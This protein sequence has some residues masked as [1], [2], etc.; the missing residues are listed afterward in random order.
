MSK[1]T[2]NMLRYA[3]TCFSTLP[4]RQ[5]NPPHNRLRYGRQVVFHRQGMLAGPA[6]YSL[7]RHLPAGL[8]LR[9]P[10]RDQ[11]AHL[12]ANRLSISFVRHQRPP[13]PRLYAFRP[14]P[15]T[16]C[17]NIHDLANSLQSTAFSLPVPPRHQS[18]FSKIHDLFQH[19]HVMLASLQ[20]FVAQGIEARQ[21][22]TTPLPLPLHQI[23]ATR[24]SGAFI[25]R[26]SQENQ[27]PVFS[28]AA[29]ADQMQP[30]GSGILRLHRRQIKCAAQIP[31]EC[32]LVPPPKRH[33]SQGKI[34]QRIGVQSV[35]FIWIG[36]ELVATP[37]H[38]Q[39]LAT[40][41]AGECP[42]DLSYTFIQIQAHMFKFWCKMTPPVSH[43]QFCLMQP[44]QH[45]PDAR[46]LRIWV[47]PL[48]TIHDLGLLVAD[49]LL[50]TAFSLQP[51]TITLPDGSD[52][53]IC[54]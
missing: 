11:P 21:N 39:P 22:H 54:I 46:F 10:Q 7:I 38:I 4:L 6:V 1:H 20:E 14:N 30:I 50:L 32:R 3:S 35:V 8:C 49:F 41:R 47:V 12:R 29:A 27:L 42:C 16:H 40:A 5:V 44:G 18:A 31:F 13:P 19:E 33:I 26:E 45:F 34:G 53:I 43:R 37:G 2:I 28:D 23:H 52:P 48:R 51:F 17:P 25:R 36:D 24:H 9:Q 15:P